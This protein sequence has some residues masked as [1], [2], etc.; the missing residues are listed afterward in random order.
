LAVVLL[1]AAAGF[2]WWDA[3][4]VLRERYWD[5]VASSRPA[6]YWLW[7]DLAALGFSAG[8]VMFA[9]V[10]QTLGQ[11]RTYCVSA[12]TRPVLVLVAAAATTVA[13]ADLSLMSKGEVERIWLPFVPW[14]LI[15]C[16]LLPARWA[17]FGLAVQ[18]GTALLLS[19]LL[20][21]PR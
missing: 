20:S 11:T 12:T 16:A 18:L 8:P 1:F 6:S 5:G 14:L 9:G 15:G 2:A 17:R 21:I 7:A 13:V 10:A 4:P 3:F 19:N